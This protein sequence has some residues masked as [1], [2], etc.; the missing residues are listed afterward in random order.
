M[1]RSEILSRTNAGEQYQTIINIGKDPSERGFIFETICIMLLCSK[2]L[3]PDYESISD[4]ILDVESMV[5]TPVKSMKE[6][7]NKL[8][9]SGNNLSDITIKTCKGWC[10]WSIKYKDTKGKSDL[11]ECKACMDSYLGKTGDPYELGYICKDKDNLTKHH[12]K[13]RPEAVVT[14]MARQS[15]NLLDEK[16]VI[17]SFTKFQKLLRGFKF[18]TLDQIIEWM[19][20]YYLNSR[21][22]H[23]IPKFHQNL[24]LHLFKRNINQGELTHCLSHK[25]RSGKTITMLL[26]A[27][28]LLNSGYK[29]I[30]IMTSVPDT[31]NS[32]IR[33]LN[34]YIEF[35]GI[36]YKEQGSFV[37]IDDSFHGIVFCSVQYLKSRYEK[38]KDNLLLFDCNIFDECHFHS[39]NKNT[40]D[41]I[42]NIHNDKKIMQVFASGTSGKTEWF[43]NI[44]SKCIYKWYSEDECM[45]KKYF[46]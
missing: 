33:E 32:F 18:N 14:E 15:G 20:D 35:R 43:Y 12:K 13:G 5:F 37:N 8:I 42:I 16:D 24:S 3:I 38:K 23:L 9:K 21:R 19:D 34:K 46:K 10:P 31:I 40:L 36:E 29:R 11:V 41:K 26:M 17:L 45:M 28:E 7:F 4:S 44:P 25:P 6:L 30:L 39:S 1:Q 2:H 27:K 22:V